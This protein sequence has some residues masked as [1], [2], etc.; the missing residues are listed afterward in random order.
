MPSSKLDYRL[1]ESITL[2]NLLSLP[3]PGPQKLACQYP[4]IKPSEQVAEIGRGNFGITTKLDAKPVIATP[5]LFTCYAILGYNYTN[6]IG[7]LMHI[8]SPSKLQHGLEKIHEEV[9]KLNPDYK[10]QFATRIVASSYYDPRHISLLE[11]ILKGNTL[12][13]YAKF[14]Y[15]KMIEFEPDFSRAGKPG[16]GVALDTRTGNLY[17]FLRDKVR[18]M[19]LDPRYNFEI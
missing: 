11:S 15:A 5:G 14:D 18:E 7:F 19:P 13:G 16:E 3:V 12:N 4:V 1:L 17:A 8:S 6:G 9:L 2:P 10:K